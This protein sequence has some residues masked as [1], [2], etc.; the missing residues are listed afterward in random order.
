[1]GFKKYPI[2]NKINKEINNNGQNETKNDKVFTY[3]SPISNH[4]FIGK[5]RFHNLRP[6]E[7]GA[8]IS[9]LTLHG[10]DHLYHN[11][12]GAKPYGY[13]KIKIV[14]K[15]EQ[16]W[17]KYLSIFENYLRENNINLIISQQLNE[18]LAMSEKPSVEIDRMLKYPT[19]NQDTKINEF[20]EYKKDRKYLKSYSEYK[21]IFSKK[22]NEQ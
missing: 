4:S 3:F 17:K 18:L 6:Q 12:G 15:N 1:R 2:Q 20:S 11:I 14:L 8:L 13:G 22:N 19:L 21:T 10:N 5:L 16:K 9:A 7:I